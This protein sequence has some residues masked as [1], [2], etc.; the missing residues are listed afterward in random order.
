MKINIYL[1]KK[2]NR[3]NKAALTNLNWKIK[4]TASLS[5]LFLNI[6]SAYRYMSRALLVFQKRIPVQLT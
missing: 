2:L 1:T 5:L 3:E 6:Q 4:Q